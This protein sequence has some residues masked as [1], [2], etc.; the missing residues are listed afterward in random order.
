MQDSTIQQ[1][2]GA[3]NAEQEANIDA[4]PLS[5]PVD[6]DNDD[7]SRRARANARVAVIRAAI[8][9][10]W[11]EPARVDECHKVEVIDATDRQEIW[12]MTI[13]Q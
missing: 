12:T 2:L 7:S 1:A 4:K 5:R 11:L 6:A 13:V 3:E 9:D 8:E 10:S